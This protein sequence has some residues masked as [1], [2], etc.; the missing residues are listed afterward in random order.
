[1][2]RSGELRQP[3]ARLAVLR[4]P[5]P[6]TTTFRA[7]QPRELRIGSGPSAHLLL[8]ASC[9]APQQLEVCWDGAALWLQDRLRL[10]STLVQGRP[11]GEWNLVR[12]HVIVTFGAIRLW[13]AAASP[14]PV[15][16]APDLSFLDQARGNLFARD[17]RRMPTLRLMPACEL[18]RE[19][20]SE[21]AGS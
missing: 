16:D 14:L 11:L 18:L 9:A 7:G 13:V 17:Y 3:W 8:P 12:G 21:A 6:H 1:M 15:P 20:L 4:G 10:G 5:T 2:Q 19:T